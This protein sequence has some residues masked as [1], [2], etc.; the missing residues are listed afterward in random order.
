MKPF[1]AALALGL[2]TLSPL[3]AQ[4]VR[5]KTYR[6]GA[7]AVTVYDHAF[8]NAEEKATLD[9]V[10]TNEQALAL[11]VTKPGRYSAMAVSPDDGFIRGGQ[12]VPSAIALSDLESRDAARAAVLKDCNAARK[13]KKDCLLVLEVAPSS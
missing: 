2:M 12:P 3:Q 5:G 8:L 4:E 6:L 7:Q 10:A 11:F 9:L 13:G 1:V